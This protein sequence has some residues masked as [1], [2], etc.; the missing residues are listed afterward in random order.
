MYAIWVTAKVKPEQR[1]RFLEIIEDDAICSERDEPGC[2]RFNVLQDK[3]NENTYYFYEVYRDEAAFQAHIQTPHLARLREAAPEI[4]STPTQ[5]LEVTPLF[6]R[7]PAYW[8]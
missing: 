4:F 5:R 8:G 6:P 3:A 2:L 1:Q 7:D